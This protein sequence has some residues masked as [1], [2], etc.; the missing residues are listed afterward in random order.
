MQEHLPPYGPP[1]RV[2]KATLPITCDVQRKLKTS[3]KIKP[4]TV[5]LEQCAPVEHARHR[6]QMHGSTLDIPAYMDSQAYTLHSCRETLLVIDYR[7]GVGC[8]RGN[9]SKSKP[10]AERGLYD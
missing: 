10:D 9:G 2:A 5:P 6:S 1:A 4:A 8:A 3:K 7:Q